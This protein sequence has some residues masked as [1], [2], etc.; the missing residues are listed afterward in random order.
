MAHTN[1]PWSY[2]L[3]WTSSSRALDEINSTAD[4]WW[5]W[6]RVLI[7]WQKFFTIEIPYELEVKR[8]DNNIECVLRD[9]CWVIVLNKHTSDEFI[10][11]L[12]FAF[13]KEFGVLGLLTNQNFCG[14]ALHPAGFVFDLYLI[15]WI[16][17]GQSTTV[18]ADNYASFSWGALCEAFLLSGKTCKL[19]LI[20]QFLGITVLLLN[21]AIPKKNTC[22]NSRSNNN[23]PQ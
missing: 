13:S 16:K 20:L 2:I 1:P 22:F 8:I 19:M 6:Q 3:Q 21:F 12:L 23:S 9:H 11:A 18:R 7:R 5:F 14:C 15:I 4:I 10:V 17:P